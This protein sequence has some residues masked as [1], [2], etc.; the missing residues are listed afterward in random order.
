ME[1][2]VNSTIGP[3]SNVTV[4]PNVTFHCNGTC[5]TMPKKH[6]FRRICMVQYYHRLCE[7]DS[8]TTMSTC[9]SFWKSG[10]HIFNEY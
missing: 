3:F 5:L 4:E 10:N 9:W 2:I 1:D 6:Y 8:Y 7:Y